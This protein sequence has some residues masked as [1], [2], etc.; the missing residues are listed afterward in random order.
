MPRGTSVTL[1]LKA[2]AKEFLD[3]WKIRQ[4][5]RTYSDHIAH[6]DH[7]GAPAQGRRHQDQPRTSRSRSTRPRAIW[8]RP[9]AEITDE[10]YKEFYHHVAHAFDEPFARV[11]FTAEGMLSYTALLF[12]PSTRPFDLLRPQA[13]ARREAL[14][15]PRVHHRATSKRCC[16]A[17]CASS[18]GVVDSEDLQLNV[19]RETLQHGAVIAKMRKALV[20]RLLDELA[21]K[22][23]AGRRRRRGRGRRDRALRRAGGPS[24]ARC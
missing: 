10:Q 15:P 7:P 8:T 5:V 19:S 3:S 13:P 23:K 18:R 12:V 24:S 14:C 9:K 20:R 16:R 1:H 11:H 21:A 6:A 22:A 2:D 17:I 4:I